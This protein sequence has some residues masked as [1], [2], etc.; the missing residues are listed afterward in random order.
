VQ[1]ALYGKAYIEAAKRTWHLVK[2]RGIDAII[3]DSLI[4]NVLSAGSVFIAYITAL[5]AYLYL[6]Y[7][8]PAYNVGGG[9]TPIVMAISFLVGLQIGNTAVQAIASGVATLF[10]CTAENPEILREYFPALFQE[11]SR[12]YPQIMSPV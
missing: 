10:V 8:A 3:N 5:L 4:A 9:Y 1:V 2:T 11:M 12:V 6:K 7:T